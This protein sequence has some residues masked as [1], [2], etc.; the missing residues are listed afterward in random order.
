MI[1]TYAYKEIIQNLHTHTHTHIIKACII[2]HNERKKSNKTLYEERGFF[3]DMV[4]YRQHS[5]LELANW[6]TWC[7]LDFI[8]EECVACV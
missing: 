7:D 1:G 4:K 2:F 8:K 6:H 5:N 3:S